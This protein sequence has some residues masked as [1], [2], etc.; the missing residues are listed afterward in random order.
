[1]FSHFGVRCVRRAAEAR[2]PAWPTLAPL[3]PEV[4]MIDQ[5]HCP[6]HRVRLHLSRLSDC[7]S[8]PF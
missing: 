6:A 5:C 1:M 7:R 3:R 4:M 2:H 8:L